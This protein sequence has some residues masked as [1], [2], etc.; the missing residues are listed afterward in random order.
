MSLEFRGEVQLRDINL[1]HQ[2]IGGV[3]QDEIIEGLSS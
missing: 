2:C 1:S 3:R